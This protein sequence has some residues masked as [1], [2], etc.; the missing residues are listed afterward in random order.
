MALKVSWQ[1]KIHNE[2]IHW[3]EEY[4]EVIKGRVPIVNVT[5]DQ[6]VK[7]YKTL[8]RLPLKV[9]NKINKTGST[10]IIVKSGSKKLTIDTQG[11]DYPRYKSLVRRI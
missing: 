3:T 8:E 1:R 7:I 11:Y 9:M 2:P 10:V 5:S 4:A 6:F